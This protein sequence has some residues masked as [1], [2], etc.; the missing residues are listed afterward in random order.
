[1]GCM[2]VEDARVPRGLAWG[3]A[4]L[5]AV[6][7]GQGMQLLGFLGHEGFHLNLFTGRFANAVVGILTSA[8][9]VVFVQVG[10]A[11]EHVHHHRYANTER[12]PDVRLFGRQK[13][14]LT[15]LLLCRV[16][17]NREFLGQALLLARG[18]PLEFG[19]SGL[20]FS[21]RELQRLAWVNFGCCLGWLGVYAWLAL[22]HPTLFVLVYG[23]PLLAA[24]LLSGVRPYLEHC[25]TDTQLATCARSRVGFWHT[26]LSVG[27]SY[28]LEHHLYPG[29]PSY[30]LPGV[31]RWLWAQGFFEAGSSLARSSADTGRAHQSLHVERTWYP[32]WRWLK[33]AHRYGEPDV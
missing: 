21:P 6:L 19:A 17:A 25:N 28:H 18:K 27:N 4:A 5:F 9:T 16:R 22:A 8:A 11:A 26:V 23:L 1:M 33:A 3:V 24:V 15:R 13:T 30:R 14:A 29:V 20:A 12:D 10:V 32:N 7:S 31:H 2:L